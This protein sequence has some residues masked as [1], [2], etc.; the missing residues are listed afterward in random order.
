MLNDLR[1]EPRAEQHDLGIMANVALH[2]VRL[3][4]PRLRDGV[5][6]WLDANGIAA[7]GMPFLRCK[8]SSILL[9]VSDAPMVMLWR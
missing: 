8:R 6:A 4:L 7:E 9:L 1:L 3:I 2:E 5:F